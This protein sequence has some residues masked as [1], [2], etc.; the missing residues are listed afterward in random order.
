MI[1]PPVLGSN[2]HTPHEGE[3]RDITTTILQHRQSS[4]YKPVQTIITKPKFSKTV[5]Q[6]ISVKIQS[7]N[8]GRE[9]DGYNT[10]QRYTKLAQ[11]RYHS[12]GSLPAE[13]VSHSTDQP[14]GKEQGQDKL[15]TWPSKLI[16]EKGFQQQA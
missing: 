4:D 14:G 11:A 13:D 8:S 6:A 7:L 9:N 1:Q 5:I 3:S 16:P 15:A 10:S 2:K 12:S